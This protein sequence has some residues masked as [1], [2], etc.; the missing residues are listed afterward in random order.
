MMLLK[1]MGDTNEN[2][3]RY[4]DGGS[5]EGGQDRAGSTGRLNFSDR[6]GDG[7]ETKQKSRL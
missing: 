3:Y 6:V 7:D 4:K 1:E 2:Y 5:A